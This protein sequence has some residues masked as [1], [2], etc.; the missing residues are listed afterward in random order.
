[1]RYHTWWHVNTTWSP[2]SSLIIMGRF[3]YSI[4]LIIFSLPI[5]SCGVYP[6]KYTS[7][8]LPW[9]LFYE[10]VLSISIG[11]IICLIHI[12]Q[13]YTSSLIIGQWDEI[14]PREIILWDIGKIDQ[15]LATNMMTS[16]NGNIFRV[17]GPLCGEFT[18]PD[19]FPSQRPVT[20]SFDVFFDLRLNTRLSEQSWSWW[21]ETLSRPFR[22][23][24]NEIGSHVCI[25]CGAP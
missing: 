20:R 23:H 8:G 13:P 1:M 17:T 10:A 18:G 3:F 14:S 25:S 9:V 24:S 5:Q 2:F 21:F 11:F 15:C 12:R 4:S 22:L 16:S 19:E 7:R 6:I